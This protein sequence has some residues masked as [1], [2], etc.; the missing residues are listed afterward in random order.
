M[1]I[2]RCSLQQYLYNNSNILKYIGDQR[3]SKL[4]C[5]KILKYY[6]LM[7]WDIYHFLTHEGIN[8]KRQN[9]KF[10]LDYKTK[11]NKWIIEQMNKTLKNICIIY[12]SRIFYMGFIFL[13]EDI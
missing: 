3:L 7:N 4:L 5:I 1:C 6:I 13:P 9:V 11:E 10:Y 8:L 2:Q 12:K